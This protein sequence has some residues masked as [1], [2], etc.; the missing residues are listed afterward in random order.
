MPRAV[1]VFGHI[2]R[3]WEDLDLVSVS[4]TVQSEENSKACL[5]E[6]RI[7]N[8]DYDYARVFTEQVSKRPDDNIKQHTG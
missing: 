4:A 8:S 2:P 5:R 6:N 3:Q 1:P 7:A